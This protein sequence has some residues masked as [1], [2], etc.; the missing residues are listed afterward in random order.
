MLNVGLGLIFVSIA[1][2]VS[3]GVYLQLL[4]MG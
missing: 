3:F 2:G 4:G 1:H